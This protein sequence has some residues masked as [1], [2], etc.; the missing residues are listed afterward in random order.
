MPLATTN[1]A[2]AEPKTRDHPLLWPVGIVA[3]G[4]VT[5]TVALW[6]LQN[7][8]RSEY[9]AAATLSMSQSWHN[10]FFGALDQAGTVSLDKMPG[11]FWIPA[12]FVRVFG[13]STWA[14]NAPNALALVGATLIAAFTARRVAGSFGGLLAG[15]LVAATPIFMAVS[16]SNQ[17]ESFFVLTIAATAW[18]GLHALQQ[19]SLKWLLLAGGFAALGFQTYMLEAWAA[20]PALG[21]AYLFVANKKLWRRFA[22]V[23][24]AGI[25]SAALS[26]AWIIV[27]S[28]VPASNRPYLGGTYTNSPWEMVFG[29]NGLGRFS[30]TQNLGTYRSFTPPFSGDPSVLRLFN[31]E[32][33]SQIAWLIPAA[34]VA[35]VALAVMKVRP[36][37]VI[38]LGGWF[39][40]MCVMFS[41]VAG[42]H[43]FYTAALAVPIALLVSIAFGVAGR[44]RVLWPQW[45]ML[46]AAVVTAWVLGLRTSDY[47]G[48]AMPV[49]TVCALGAAG[50]VMASHFGW[51]PAQKWW[52][53]LPVMAGLALTPAVWSVDTIN[54]PNS[55]NPVAGDGSASG[56]GGPGGG[57]GGNTGP[58]NTGFD[59]GSPGAIPGGDIPGGDMPSGNSGT[60]EPYGAP[61]NGMPGGNTSD[62]NTSVGSAPGG[63][64]TSVLDYVTQNRDGATYLLAVFGAQTAASYITESGGQEVLP[65]GGFSGDDPAPTLAKFRALVSSGQLHFVQTGGG[66]GSGIGINTGMGPGGGPDGSMPGG[67]GPGGGNPNG[68]NPN[69]GSPGGGGPNSGGANGQSTTDSMPSQI[70]AWVTSNCTAVSGMSDLYYCG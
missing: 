45:A 22:D 10:W 66:D 48:W 25:A 50:L 54:H 49:Q 59:G 60:G 37:M 17:P 40:T 58:G 69:G 14:V 51:R 30:A 35:I 24:I 46:G 64:D 8:Q 23:A 9:Y 47:M 57:M 32:V 53:V 31:S 61:P 56:M 11:S 4:V 43:Q 68:G 36:A 19:S 2:Q 21:L 42:M 16:K 39:A 44:Q 13:F 29:Y 6:Q 1:T 62:G 28:L 34:V 67:A 5:L 63:S 65:I 27:V 20:W 70:S 41:V 3:L 7:G 18:A 55:M 33:G 15:F 52:V 12:L 38:F 26:L